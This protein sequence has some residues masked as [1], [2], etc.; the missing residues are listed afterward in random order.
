MAMKN[1]VIWGMRD[2]DK[3]NHWRSLNLEK[4]SPDKPIVVCIGGNGTITE[5]S[6][7]AELRF[8]TTYKKDGDGDYYVRLVSTS[9]VV[10]DSYK[11]TIKEPLNAG[12][13]IVIVVVVGVIIA[14]TT[15]VIVL[16]RKM[17]IR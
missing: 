9:G 1:E 16:R 13:I 6:A 5:N 7:N 3:S 17:R 12:A 2:L 4:Y 11:V 15:T 14:V 8:E 10:L